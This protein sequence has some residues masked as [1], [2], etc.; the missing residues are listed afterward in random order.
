MAVTAN[1]IKFFTSTNGLGGAITLTEIVSGNLHN[2]FDIVNKE[3]SRDGDVEYRCIYVKNTNLVD[4]FED[5]SAF[6]SAQTASPSTSMAFGLGT[7]AVGGTE[8]SIVDESTAPIGVTFTESIG[9]A[10][11]KNIGS[12]PAGQIKAIWLRRTVQAGTS[13]ASSDVSTLSV[14]GSTV[15]A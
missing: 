4:S 15:D 2:V 8:Q 9:A 13:S 11:A 5:V 6:L 1:Q 10:Y 14:D 3:E 7:A 12:I